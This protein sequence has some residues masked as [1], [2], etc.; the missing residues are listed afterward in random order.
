ME[1]NNKSYQYLALGDSYTIG[2]DVLESDSFPYQLARLLQDQNIQVENPKIIAKTGWTTTDLI[3]AIE[4]EKIDCKYDFVTLLIGVNNH[5]QSK[6]KVEYRAE[7]LQLILKAVDFAGGRNDRV[8]VLSIPDYGVTDFGREKNVDLHISNEIDVFNAI[9]KAVAAAQRVS[10][11][12][13]TTTSREAASDGTLTASDK[14]HPS[15]KMY[16]MWNEVL[17]P[18]LVSALQYH[19]E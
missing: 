14:L 19:K 3:S 8:F 10:F 18:Y 1:V 16:A 5:Y 13:I 2:E 9:G 12:D 4:T 11:V 7:L 15:G 6:S 17:L